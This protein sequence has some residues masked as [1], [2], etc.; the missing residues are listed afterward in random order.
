MLSAKNTLVLIS[1]SLISTYSFGASFKID[2]RDADLDRIAQTYAK[3]SGDSISHEGPLKGRISIVN[4][5]PIDSAE[6]YKVITAAF[7]TK[8][9]GIFRAGLSSSKIIIA[10]GLADSAQIESGDNL[11]L[12]LPVTYYARTFKIKNALVNTVEL[13]LRV[14][15]SRDGQIKSNPDKKSIT[16]TDWSTSHQLSNVIIN[17]LEL[18]SSA[19]RG[20][21]ETFDSVNPPSLSSPEN[22]L[23]DQLSRSR[24]TFKF[25]NLTTTEVAEIFSKGTGIT[26]VVDGSSGS[27]TYDS[28]GEINGLEAFHQMSLLFKKDRI[29]INRFENFLVVQSVLSANKHLSEYGSQLKN[30]FPERPFCLIYRFKKGRVNS[31]NETLG[32][33]L[34]KDAEFAVDMKS[35]VVFIKDWT[36]S[37]SQI[38]P[39]LQQLDVET[40]SLQ[41]GNSSP[42]PK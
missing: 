3:E 40:S 5:N 32:S 25:S 34:T 7:A 28:K 39:K 4:P 9:Y 29:A 18:L 35:N 38:I 17:E 2:F 13:N 26:M 31:A 23:F 37:I 27:Y 10:A 12:T 24:F 30:E 33:M 6:A 41:K 15:T 22:S 14:L 11:P 36:S 8:G 20:T 1:S 19:G 21:K 16:V 42:N